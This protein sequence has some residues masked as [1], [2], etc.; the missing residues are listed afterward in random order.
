MQQ[1]LILAAMA[2]IS[3][4]AIAGQYDIHTSRLSDTT[5]YETERQERQDAEYR[6]RRDTQ[7]A[8]WETNRRLDI[9]I[10]QTAPRRPSASEEIGAAIGSWYRRR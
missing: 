6:A 2:A 8:Q 9:L 5:S 4:S 3:T 7:Q 1:R 10:E